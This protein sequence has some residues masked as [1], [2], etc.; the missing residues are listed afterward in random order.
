MRQGWIKLHR[1][2]LDHWIFDNPR[3]LKWWLWLLLNANTGPSKVMVRGRVVQLSVGQLVT[4]VRYLRNCWANLDALKRGRIYP[5]R[6]AVARFLHLL[7]NEEMITYDSKNISNFGTVVTICNFERYQGFL[8]PPWDSD[9]TDSGQPADSDETDSGQPA[10]SDDDT[11]ETPT[12]QTADKLK[13][14]RNKEY[15]NIYGGG[16]DARAREEIED[17]EYFQEVLRQFFA[18]AR[19][20]T[21]EQLCMSMKVTEAELRGLAIEATSEWTGRRENIGAEMARLTSHLRAKKAANDRDARAAELHQARMN[22]ITGGETR[23]QA[24]ERMRLNALRR[25]NESGHDPGFNEF[26]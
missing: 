4:S 12:R 10:D 21:I 24:Q 3:Y 18:P 15:K 14:I 19:Q 5:T 9:E 6:S 22:K 11:N 20:A 1:S 16:G 7:K 17:F 8:T 2:V 13:N 25:L 23:E 26:A